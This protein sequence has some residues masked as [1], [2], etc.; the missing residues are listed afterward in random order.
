VLLFTHVVHHRGQL[1]QMLR[2]LGLRP[3]GFL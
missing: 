1:Y 3:P 2:T